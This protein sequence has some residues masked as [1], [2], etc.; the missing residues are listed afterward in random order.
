MLEYPLLLVFP[1]AMVFA[2]AFDLLTMTIPNRIS[3]TL[4]V[5]FALVATLSGLS[6]TAIAMHVGASMIVLAAGFFLFVRGWL[7]GGDAKLLAASALWLGFDSLSQFL[8]MVGLLGGVLSG[9]ILAFR[10]YVPGRFLSGPHWLLR[11]HDKGNG[12][13]YGLA[14]ASAALL[15]YP[16][17]HWFAV[18]IG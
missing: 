9:L 6:I 1:I 17:T 12:I 16:D 7:G 13:P 14:I 5:A 3:M 2:G 8:L 18:L 11:L 10:V 4:V 15:I